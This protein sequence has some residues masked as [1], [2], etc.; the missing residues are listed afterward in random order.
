M[1]SLAESRAGGQYPTSS[2][3]VSTAICNAMALSVNLPIASTVT[4]RAASFPS[5]GL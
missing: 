5:A 4:R 1:L 2:I 3:Q